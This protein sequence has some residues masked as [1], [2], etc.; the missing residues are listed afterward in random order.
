MV[1]GCEITEN[2]A[3]FNVAK[4]FNLPISFLIKIFYQFLSFMVINF[5]NAVLLQNT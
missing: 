5:L 3:L 4:I 1:I 2:L